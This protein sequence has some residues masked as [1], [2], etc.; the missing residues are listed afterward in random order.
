MLNGT[1][2]FGGTEICLSWHSFFCVWMQCT[3]FRDTGI[4]SDYDGF[5]S[6]DEDETER[7][8]RAGNTQTAFL[9]RRSERDKDDEDL[10]LR[11]S[12]PPHASRCLPVQDVSGRG[13]RGA[14][15]VRFNVSSLTWREL[16]FLQDV[17]AGNPRLN[18]LLLVRGW[19][20]AFCRAPI[21]RR[22]RR[23]RSRRS[24]ST[25]G[26]TAA[27][28]AASQRS[29]AARVGGE[30]SRTERALRSSCGRVANSHKGVRRRHQ[31]TRDNRDATR[32][33]GR[34]VG[35]RI[36]EVVAHAKFNNA[37]TPCQ[38]GRHVCWAVFLARGLLHT[39][40]LRHVRVHQFL[41]PH[42]QLLWARELDIS[43]ALL[44]V[45]DIA[46]VPD[47]K[48]SWGGG[49]GGGL[50]LLTVCLV[51]CACARFMMAVLRDNQVLEKLV[52]THIVV[53][54]QSIE[55]ICRMLRQ[56]FHLQH[57]NLSDCHV[58]RPQA[59]ALAASVCRNSSLQTLQLH[60]CVVCVEPCLVMQTRL[61]PWR[62][63]ELR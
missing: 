42:Q 59:Q 43:G 17:L 32:D 37:V 60:E 14:G 44:T 62:S 31:R 33:A 9:L 40:S 30:P 50:A 22:R 63:C 11:Y 15:N 6:S 39:H 51:W 4:P 29:A 53:D 20:N 49:G 34:S 12:G 25:T 2:T 8:N 10:G 46:C 21:H 7:A 38:S 56:N 45:T 26:D 57:L 52:M 5:T 54:D 47:G 58:T 61:P 16:V 36:S 55:H 1:G 23:R 27:H 24:S 41:I 28:A 48:R 13:L 35:D 18:K 3:L 19:D